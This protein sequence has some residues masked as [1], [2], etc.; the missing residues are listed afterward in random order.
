MQNELDWY[1]KRHEIFWSKSD[2]DNRLVCISYLLRS[3]PTSTVV[4]SQIFNFIFWGFH[5]WI[6]Y[7]SG[8][9]NTDWSTR[10]TKW[11]LG[12]CSSAKRKAFDKSFKLKCFHM[13]ISMQWLFKESTSVFKIASL[14]SYLEQSIERV[15]SA[16]Y[17][18]VHFW[19]SHVWSLLL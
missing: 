9:K 3:T 6:E 4:C 8:T 5:V 14:Q 17:Q 7:S 10:L 18:V 19:A 16:N 2:G 1:L 15:A 11:L 12:E 13:V